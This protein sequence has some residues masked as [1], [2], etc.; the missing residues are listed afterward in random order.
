MRRPRTADA[1]AR[2]RR[3]GVRPG[4]GNRQP[5]T[6]PALPRVVIAVEHYGRIARTLEKEMPVTIEMDI[7]NSFQD[8]LT[9]F[10]VVADLP[11]TDKA[12]EIVMLGAHFDSW[13]GGTGA[14]DNAAGSAVMMEAMRILK[15][16]GLKLRRTVR[17]GLWGG[18][19]QG[20]NGSRAYVLQHFGNPQ[21]MELSR[22]MRSS[23]Y[24][25]TSTTARAIRAFT[26]RATRRWRRSSNRG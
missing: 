24:T 25:S 18:E 17:I 10:N 21:T 4:G 15:Q 5:N 2:R 7:R 9:S 6:D 13:H 23:P 8:D 3:H 11:G 19:E 20:L 16:S 22:R 14:T 26:S 1:R 12:D